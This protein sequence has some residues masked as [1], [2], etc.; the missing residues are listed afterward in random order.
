MVRNGWVGFLGGFFRGTGG[1]TSTWKTEPQALPCGLRLG[2][3][4]S[5]P[6]VRCGFGYACSFLH[7]W[8]TANCPQSKDKVTCV[9]V[10]VLSKQQLPVLKFQFSHSGG[11][12]N[13]WTIFDK[14][15]EKQPKIL[16]NGGASSGHRWG[17]GLEP[18]SQTNRQRGGSSGSETHIFF[19]STPGMR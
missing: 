2:L 11:A 12:N 9:C 15:V 5:A 19:N 14:A 4:G 6:N 8:P 18:R 17:P 1:T 16:A 3:L 7:G 10:C 13:L